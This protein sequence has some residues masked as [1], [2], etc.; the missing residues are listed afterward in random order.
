MLLL[1]QSSIILK[2]SIPSFHSVTA[3]G[4]LLL[5]TSHHVI[6]VANTQVMVV[7]DPESQSPIAMILIWIDVRSC[8]LYLEYC[9]HLLQNQRSISRRAPSEDDLFAIIL[10]YVA[11]SIY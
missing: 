5:H 11:K 10:W 6:Y 8:V 7:N 4:E 2:G 1:V 9:N 3:F